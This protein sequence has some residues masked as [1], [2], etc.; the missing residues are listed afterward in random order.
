MGLCKNNVYIVTC[1][2]GYTV[3]TFK[4]SVGEKVAE[5]YCKTDESE[6]STT[7]GC[8]FFINFWCRFSLV[9]LNAKIRISHVGFSKKILTN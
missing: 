7:S 2:D 6:Y 1:N 8:I 4:Y 9:F 3:Q 5:F